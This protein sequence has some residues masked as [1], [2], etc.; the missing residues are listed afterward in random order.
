[1]TDTKLQL[2]WGY[3]RDIPD[4]VKAVWG[5]RLIAPS[6]L[7]SSRQ[8][9]QAEN[10]A[11]KDRL[12]TWLNG[13]SPAEDGGQKGTGAIAKAQEFLRAEY[14]RILR[15]DQ[16]CPFTLYEDAQ[17]VIIGNALASHGY[18]YVVGYLRPLSVHTLS[19]CLTELADWAASQ[20]QPAGTP[21]I[22]VQAKEAGYGPA[23]IAQIT[24]AWE[25]GRP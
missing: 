16:D 1:M 18:V 17:G 14:G 6:Q 22:Y 21:D 10:H 23:A 25:A 19:H 15:P 5:A 11:E 13:W 12:I 7:V 3:K 2:G 24:Y 9:L 8:D 4:D 20:E